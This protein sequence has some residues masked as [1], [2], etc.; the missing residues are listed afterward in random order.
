MSVLLQLPSPL[1]H[2][3]HTLT[4]VG[5]LFTPALQAVALDPLMK[6]AHV[7]LGKIYA[8][9][10][11]LVQA[12]RHLERALEVAPLCVLESLYN[13]WYLLTVLHP[14]SLVIS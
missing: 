8:K 9:E 7:A 13:C 2:S 14:G 1:P 6:E 12:T 3:A 5:I 11:K 10:G 4:A